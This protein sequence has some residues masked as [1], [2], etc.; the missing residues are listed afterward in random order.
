MA[1]NL[2]SDV[3]V[4]ELSMYAFA[5]A[6]AAVLSDWGADVIKV[7]PPDSADPM[8]GNSIAGL[9]PV[10]TGISFMWEQLNRGKRCMCIDVS[11]AEGRDLLLRI[12][13]DTDVFITNLLPGARRRFGIDVD[14]VR[15]VN[16]GIIYARASGH[17]DRGPEREKGGFDHTDFW[18][19]T[20]IGHAASMA[21]GEFVP[22]AGPAMGDS[23]SGAFLAGAIAAALYQ[24]SRTGEGAEIDVSLLSAGVWMFGPAVIASQLYD[25]D[26][27]PRFSHAEQKNALVTAYATRDGRQIYFSGIRTD[28]GFQELADLIGHPELTHDP[29]FN[30]NLARVENVRDLIGKLDEIFATRDLADWVGRLQPCSTPWAVVQSA[31]EVA[32]DPQVLANSYVVTVE[33]EARRYPVTGSPAQFDGAAPT[34][35]RAPDHGE[36]TEQILLDLGLAWD[37]VER[38]KAARVVN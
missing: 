28:K 30:S 36:H 19:R 27:I 21:V 23:A 31:R 37:E 6:C 18:A 1:Y 29:R 3:K 35:T 15:K 4:I 10:E 8:R 17:G 7:V 22:Q 2:L 13:A 25:I 38:L 20:G 24:R 5:P 16:P 14:D 26:T 11:Q 33:G 12:L 34:L 9:P 32:T